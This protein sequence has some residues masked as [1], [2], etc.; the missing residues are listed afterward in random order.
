MLLRRSHSRQSRCRRPSL[1]P[2]CSISHLKRHAL[3]DAEH[4]R[5]EPVVA[6]APR[7]ARSR[8]PPACRSTRGRGR[9]R[10]SAASRSSSPTNASGR[11]Q[12][13][14]PQR[15]GAVDLRAVGQLRRRVDRA[16]GVA[17]CARRRPRRSSRARSRSDPS[18]CGSSRTPGSRGAPPSARASSAACSRSALS[19]SGGTSGGGGGGGV[20]S[21]FS[22]IHLPRSDRR[23]PVR[24][25]T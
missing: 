18:A 6:R 15:D 7:R 22:R 12:Q 16:A 4:E 9:A 3:D 24:R 20:P 13:R 5:R 19:L 2:T 11:L 1:A 23:R 14:L 8:A 25:A 10:R 21:R 17:W